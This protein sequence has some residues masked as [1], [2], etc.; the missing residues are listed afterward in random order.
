MFS[1]LLL[2][3][4]SQVG[5]RTFDELY[6]KRVVPLSQVVWVDSSEATELMSRLIAI[7]RVEVESH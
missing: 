1:L 6:F 3:K 5:A 2:R 4:S 7:V